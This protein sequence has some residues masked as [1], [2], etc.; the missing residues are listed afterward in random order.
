M[1]IIKYTYK[2]TETIKVKMLG[3]AAAMVIID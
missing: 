3:K 2:V 1:G